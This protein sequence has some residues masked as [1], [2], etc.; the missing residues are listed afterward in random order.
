MIIIILNLDLKY[1][2]FGKVIDGWDTLDSL[3]RAPVNA[4]NHKPV[5][6]RISNRF[7][8]NTRIP[9]NGKSTTIQEKNCRDVARDIRVVLTSNR[10]YIKFE[11][12]IFAPPPFLIY[13]FSPTEIYYNEVVCAAG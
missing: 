9:K 2:V 6:G 8:F 11:V 4:K 13:I 1:T 7:N 10:V 12:H 5:P 3:E